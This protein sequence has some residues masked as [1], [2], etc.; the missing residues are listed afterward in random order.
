MSIPNLFYIKIHAQFFFKR[1]YIV[2]G[3]CISNIL[4]NEVGQPHLKVNRLK[5]HI[6]KIGSI[7]V[8][9]GEKARGGN[10]A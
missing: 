8:K 9:E 4:G 6:I 1:D 2:K 3:E 5:W 10:I 7:L